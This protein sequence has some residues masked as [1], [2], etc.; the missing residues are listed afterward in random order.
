MCLICRYK[1]SDPGAGGDGL[2]RE[3]LVV[4]IGGPFITTVNL[5]MVVCI[6]NHSFGETE[7]RE[8]LGLLY[9][10]P[11]PFVEFQAGLL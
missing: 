7:I 9:S 5:G 6:S 2:V 11:G 3:V 1:E 4:H 10:Q 8:S